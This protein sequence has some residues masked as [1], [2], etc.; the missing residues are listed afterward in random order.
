M[1][2]VSK[3]RHLNYKLVQP[4]DPSVKLYKPSAFSDAW[5]L[6]LHPLAPQNHPRAALPA[7]RQERS[8]S[9]ERKLI[10]KQNCRYG[11]C[12]TICQ[13]PSL[14]RCAFKGERIAAFHQNQGYSREAS[15]N[16]GQSKWLKTQSSCKKTKYTHK[17]T[18]TARR[19]LRPRKQVH[20]QAPPGE[21]VAGT[22]Q[23]RRFL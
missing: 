11:E 18:C 5:S 13:S 12:Q 23:D 9:V 16:P 14:L 2:V 22:K 10:C 4:M 8:L 19:M 15:K 21:V 17:E 20:Q 1:P 7:C 3:L 6:P